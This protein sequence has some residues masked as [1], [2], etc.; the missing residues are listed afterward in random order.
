VVDE[1]ALSETDSSYVDAV[2]IES[3]ADGGFVVVWNGRVRLPGTE[4][5]SVDASTPSQ[6][7]C[8]RTLES[9]PIAKTPS[10]VQVRP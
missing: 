1:F 5:F 9:T 4:A 2:D 3:T 7:R 8:R 6:L 10:S